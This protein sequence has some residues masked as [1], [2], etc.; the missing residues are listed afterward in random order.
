[1][2]TIQTNDIRVQSARNLA[3]SLLNDP[4]YTFI[5]R[6][7]PW[8]NDNDPPVPD[9]SL[10]EY[11]DVQDELLTLKKISATD[12]VLM[13]PRLTWV[14]GIIY[15]IY[16]HDYNN[17]NKA[18]SGANNLKDAIYVVI[19]SMGRVYACLDNDRNSQSLVEPQS[20]SY[21]PFY[22]SD[23]Y[24]WQL[25]YTISANRMREYSTTNFIPVY[26]SEQPRPAGEITT[27]KIEDS[28]RGYTTSP[29]GYTNQIDYYYVPITGNGY[30]GVARIEIISGG[31]GKIDVVR[32]GRNYTYGTVNFVKDNCYASLNDYDR[33]INKLDPEGAE[34]F[35]STVII[36]P[37]GGW[38]VD[39][40]RALYA[41]R[42]GVFS[43]LK[44]DMTDSV[45]DVEFRQVGIL[46]NPDSDNDET[47]SAYKSIKVTVQKGEFEVG[48]LMQQ[49]RPDGI[50]IG[51]VVGYDSVNEIVSYIQNPQIHADANGELISFIGDYVLTGTAQATPTSFTG[52]LNGLDFIGGYA[53]S[54]IIKNTGMLT[55]LT[56]I[57]PVKRN[58][59]QTERIS[60]VISF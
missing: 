17:D 2:A 58:D 14:S 24:Q 39:N 28:G 8:E 1:M 15:D 47:L 20:E 5:G 37:V 32:G 19:N 22:T 29:K 55:Y 57:R 25:L 16:R 9:N 10:R 43:T 36:P 12:V 35:K 21:V 3:S 56:N 34:T 7:T 40:R 6:V 23:G 31:V 50:A 52:T 46:S 26:E 49:V 60:F 4:S 18:F 53:T 54:E 41:S 27:V 48:S 30:N 51:E 13:I 11:Y 33:N 42:V 44:Y 59:M 38:G 45:Q